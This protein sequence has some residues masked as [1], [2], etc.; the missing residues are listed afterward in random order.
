[1]RSKYYCI[2]GDLRLIDRFP[3]PFSDKYP[4]ISLAFTVSEDK[5]DKYLDIK[6]EPNDIERFSLENGYFQLIFSLLKT[7]DR[8]QILSAMLDSIS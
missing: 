2:I 5:R 7:I 4:T 3:P 8:D 1:M 6:E